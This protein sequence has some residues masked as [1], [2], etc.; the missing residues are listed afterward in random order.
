MSV[1]PL[2]IIER[3]FQEHNLERPE[4]VLPRRRFS[5]MF[6]ER[7]LSA[8]A[9]L[10]H[11]C[12]LQAHE[13]ETVLHLIHRVPPTRCHTQK[14]RRLEMGTAVKGTG[15]SAADCS[16]V[17]CL[18]G[19]LWVFHSPVKLHCWLFHRKEESCRSE[20][21]PITITRTWRGEQ[22]AY[23]S[24]WTLKP[25]AFCKNWEVDSWKPPLKKLTPKGWEKP[26][27][28]AFVSLLQKDLF[29]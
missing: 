3:L 12:I 24:T 28:S 1:W 15:L 7:L 8:E 22:W 11:F 19:E 23:Q 2:S 26:G 13:A 27:D 25:G 18:E 17:G 9:I 14:H 6:Q 4:S 16:P 20:L 29:S 10:C 5:P 21:H